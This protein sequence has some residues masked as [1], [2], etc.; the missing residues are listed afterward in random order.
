MTGVPQ[1]E[2]SFQY[3]AGT[4]G[5][6]QPQNLSSMA[7]LRSK[8]SAELQSADIDLRYPMAPGKGD[9]Y[10]QFS[11]PSLTIPNLGV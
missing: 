4:P 5:C 7:C 6:L 3:F 1:A 8:S 9:W 2:Y 11:I 10:V